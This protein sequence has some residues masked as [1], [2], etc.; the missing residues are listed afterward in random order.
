[1]VI[2]EDMEVIGVMEVIEEVIMEGIE[3][4]MVVT[5]GGMGAGENK[6]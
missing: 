1:M 6:I 3:G 5:V 2:E 4:V